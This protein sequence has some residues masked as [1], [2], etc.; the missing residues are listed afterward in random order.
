M[1]LQYLKEAIGLLEDL[2]AQV[3]SGVHRNPALV[4]YG[5]PPKGGEFLIRFQR[6]MA[7][8]VHE[9]WY[10]HVQ[11]GAPYK[12]AFDGQVQMWG[13]TR[14]EQRDVL[15]THQRGLPLWKDFR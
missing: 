4:V 9:L 1:A 11:D 5:N 10:E 3:A 8:D 2:Q 14:G 13:V 7:N 6:Q 15:L 12:H